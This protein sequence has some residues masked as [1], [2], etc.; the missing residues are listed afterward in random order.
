MVP[1]TDER[2]SVVFFSSLLELPAIISSS[3]LR[4]ISSVLFVSSVRTP[5]RFAPQSEI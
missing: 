5:N 1:R 2:A 4:L 3:Y